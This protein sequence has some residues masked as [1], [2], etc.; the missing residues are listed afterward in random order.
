MKRIAKCALRKAERKKIIK[1]QTFI[2][3]EKKM[4]TFI[5]KSLIFESY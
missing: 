5:S 1:K 3:K 2:R 4:K